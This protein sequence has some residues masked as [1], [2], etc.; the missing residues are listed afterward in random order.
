MVINLLNR[1]LRNLSN[2][3]NSLDITNILDIGCGEGFVIQNVF[4]WMIAMRNS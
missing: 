3:V 2:I 4:P 1:F